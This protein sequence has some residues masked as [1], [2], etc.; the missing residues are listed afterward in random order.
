MVA[1]NVYVPAKTGASTEEQ[2]AAKEYR[3]L[4]LDNAGLTGSP[5]T[6]D[7][8]DVVQ[9]LAVWHFTND[10]DAFDV[11]DSGNFSLWI[12]SVKGQDSGYNPLGDKK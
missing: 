3:D 11:G 4:L 8:I 1:R 6:D 7:D 5:L 12:N 9:Q 2:Q 10:G